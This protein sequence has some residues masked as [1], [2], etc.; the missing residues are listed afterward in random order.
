MADTAGARARGLSFRDDIPADQGMLFISGDCRTSEAGFW[1]KDTSIPLAVAF[2]SMEGAI[3][4]IQEMVPFSTQVHNVGEPYLFALEV[5]QDWFREHG[6][7]EGDF[8]ELPGPIACG[9]VR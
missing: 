6:V 4:D 7:A 3:L 5:N 1:M 9:S 2:V 8:V